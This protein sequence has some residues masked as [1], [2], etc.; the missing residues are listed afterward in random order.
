MNRQISK[1]TS[2]HPV[3][4]FF[5]YVNVSNSIEFLR[6]SCVRHKCFVPCGL[7][8]LQTMSVSDCHCANISIL[9]ANYCNLYALHMRILVIY[10]SQI[11]HDNATN[12]KFGLELSKIKIRRQFASLLFC[13]QVGTTLYMSRLPLFW[14]CF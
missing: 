10:Y 5:V 6:S 8:A 11:R 13:G 14:A 2:T 4:Q 12:V 1:S 3:S 9:T 7:F